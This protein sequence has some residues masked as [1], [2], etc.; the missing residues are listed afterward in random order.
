[1][2]KVCTWFSQNLTTDN[3]DDYKFL[4]DIKYK[5][6]SRANDSKYD[7]PFVNRARTES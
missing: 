4:M 1:M 3:Q 6:F 7:M 5:M 2:D